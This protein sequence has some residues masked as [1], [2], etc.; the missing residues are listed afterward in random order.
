MKFSRPSL[1]VLGLGL[2]TL[3]ILF[4]SFARKKSSAGASTAQKVYTVSDFLKRATPHKNGSPPQPEIPTTSATPVATA[5]APVAVDEEDVTNL[6]PKLPMGDIEML[7]RLTANNDVC[8]LRKYN[9]KVADILSVII[10]APDST[11]IDSEK[12]RTL[13][14]L[15]AAASS[16][17]SGTNV[18]IQKTEA[19]NLGSFWTALAL[20]GQL[21]FVERFDENP[22][23]ALEILEELATQDPDNGVYDYYSAPVLQDLEA[24]DAVV[25]AR[26]MRAFQKPKY[27]V[28]KFRIGLRIYQKSF[29]NSAYFAAGQNARY[30]LPAPSPWKASFVI[31]NFLNKQDDP[32]FNLAVRQFSQ[33]MID[34]NQPTKPEYESIDWSWVDASIASI[35]QIKSWNPKDG[36]NP[37][38]REQF[39]K[40]FSPPLKTNEAAIQHIDAWVNEN[41]CNKDAINNY[42][43]IQ[44]ENYLNYKEGK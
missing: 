7:R 5:A 44:K 18:S 38:N 4:V 9:F 20:S 3:L 23:R 21:D 27:D 10:D 15:F 11:E 28:S 37:Y 39:K 22:K 34:Q 31:R 13:S 30:F 14:E 16:V 12:D 40:V 26:F 8:T 17:S 43:K 36:P 41:P 6:D 32:Q 33:R 29:A 25:K 19:S 24:G 42:V 35:N 1:I 2:L